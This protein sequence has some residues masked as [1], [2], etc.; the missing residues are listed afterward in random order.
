[1]STPHPSGIAALIKS[2]HDW[3]PAAIKSTIMTTSYFLD[4]NGNSIMDEK[5][6]PADPFS[7]GAGHVDPSKA[8]DP[9]LEYDIGPDEYIGLLCSLRYTDGE[10]QIITH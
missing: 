3:T 10:V 9:G 6:H 4:N 8:A 1:M 2:M 7:M 5:I